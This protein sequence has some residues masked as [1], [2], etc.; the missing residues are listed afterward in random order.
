VAFPQTSLPLVTEI[1]VDGEWTDISSYVRYA[2]GI[3]ISGGRSDWQSKTS[4]TRCGLTIENTDGRFSPRNPTSPYYGK[5]GRNTQL[6]VRIT[7]G[8]QPS[9]RSTVTTGEGNS[10]TY[11]VALPASVAAGDLLLIFQ[12]ADVTLINFLQE[13]VGGG[14]WNVLEQMDNLILSNGVLLATRIWWRYADG[15][16]AATYTLSHGA[17]S[18]GVAIF[19]AVKDVAPGS[20][21]MHASL[22]EDLP[23]ASVVTPSLNPAGAEDFELRYVAAADGAGVAGVTWTPPAGFT[24]RADIQS[25]DF[26]TASLATRA[27]ADGTATGTHTFTCS[28]SALDAAMGFSVA[29][30]GVD[31]RFWGEVPAWPQ[32]WDTSGTD[33][34]VPLEAAGILRRLTT[35]GQQPL[36]SQL[37]RGIS[38][39]ADVVAY[40]PM[41]DGSGATVFGSAIEGVAPATYREVSPGGS[42][43]VGLGGS[44]PLAVLGTGAVVVGPVPEHDFTGWTIQFVTRVEYASAAN[45][46]LIQWVTLGGYP[47]I[48]Q[49]RFNSDDTIHLQGVDETATVIPGFDLNAGT[50]T[51]QAGL[52]AFGSWVTMYA[53]AVQSGG[54]IT[55][56]LGWDFGGGD[57]DGFSNNA[58]DAGTLA[59]LRKVQVSPLS[60]ELNGT[61]LGHINVRSSY[62]GTT[63]LTHEL[64]GTAAESA[65]DRIRR[66][67]D[68][69][70]IPFHLI[71]YAPDTVD[72]GPQ[73]ISTLITLME[74]AAE[75]DGGI[76]FEL[77]DQFGLAY[78]TR[79]D[80]QNQDAKLGLT[81]AAPTAH[82]AG[83]FLPVEDDQLLANRVTV[84]RRDGSSATSGL[85]SGS[86]STQL[87]PDGVGPYPQGV[88]LNLF[89]DSQVRD[90]AGWRRHLGTWDE[91]RYPQIGVN[92][93]R[94]VFASDA[95]L[96]ADAAQLIPGDVLSVTDLPAWL[97]PDDVTLMIQ[98]YVERLS[99][100]ERSIRWNATPA[101]PYEIFVIEGGANRGRLK[102]DNSTLISDVTTTATSLSVAT[103]E[104]P[105]WITTG[106][107]FDIEVGGERMT[108]T[109][110]S[111]A[112][113]QTFTVTRSVNGIVK[114]H[115][116]GAEVKLWRQS[117][118]ALT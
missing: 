95:A 34:Y 24:E 18:D 42:D 3:E 14:R 1:Y 117:V 70:D 96:T 33:V 66:L 83:E 5:I 37:R 36:E 12:S 104:G 71:G 13:P 62:I 46:T 51:D 61:V 87:P 74:D 82:L 58:T 84:S 94:A 108:C 109:A 79:T 115:L 45:A 20:V 4:P 41:E 44:Q 30:T 118:L 88:T 17:G 11:T 19:A 90:Q 63:D 15:T 25:N 10:D 101:G 106:D 22:Y 99:G 32:K 81:Y 86:L 113:A 54:N 68:E 55:Y 98:G 114:A 43:V 97:P 49:I 78:R 93:A 69:N 26:T 75:A 9:L 8:T 23:G 59:A 112:G 67:C 77:R 39:A 102:S 38:K 116:A 103:T 72:V 56:I 57:R 105:L 29:V 111:G 80:L 48:W 2:Q 65:A 60:S 50:F 52:S 73:G 92:L 6:R 53:T 85:A 100:H 28:S 91:A 35:G 47:E 31:V 110:I 7:G 76:L 16:E 40:W 21:P 27:L 89:D 64:M 107:D